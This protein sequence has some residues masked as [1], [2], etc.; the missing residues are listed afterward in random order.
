MDGCMSHFSDALAAL[1]PLL[2][3]FFMATVLRDLIFEFC[4]GWLL[5]MDV[6]LSLLFFFLPW[7]IGFSSSGDVLKFSASIMEV[8]LASGQNLFLCMLLAAGEAKNMAALLVLTCMSRSNSETHFD[9]CWLCSHQ[10]LGNYIYIVHIT[11]E[12]ER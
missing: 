3:L 7:I 1:T 8:L 11:Q 12:R 10:L 4:A 9:A 5:L 2:A 6:F